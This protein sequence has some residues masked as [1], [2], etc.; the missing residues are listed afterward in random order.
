M[1]RKELTDDG[2]ITLNET[3]VGKNVDNRKK[4]DVQLVQFFLHQFFL[5]KPE[6]FRKLP[7]TKRRQQVI[8]IDGAFGKQT[9]AGITVFQE[10]LKQL[11]VPIK[12]DGLVSVMTGTRSARGNPF[13]ISFLNSFFTTFGNDKEFKNNLENHPLIFSAAPELAAE[14]FISLPRDDFQG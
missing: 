5:K 10:E 7:P 6:L 9:A 4:S 8:V 1:A 12:A 11:G 3:P 13:T 14:L 2:F